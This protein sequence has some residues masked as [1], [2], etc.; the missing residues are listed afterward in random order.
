MSSVHPLSSSNHLQPSLISSYPYALID[1]LSYRIS[2]LLCTTM[3]KVKLFYLTCMHTKK[4]Y[5]YITF[6]QSVTILNHAKSSKRAAPPSPSAPLSNGKRNHCVRSVDLTLNQITISK[7][8]CKSHHP[9]NARSTNA[10]PL[11][12]RPVPCC[13]AQIISA[14]SLVTHPPQTN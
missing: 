5:A 3:R 8:I 4:R 11:S 9:R 12:A 13:T 1:L 6:G 7:V 10:F 2:L 14:R